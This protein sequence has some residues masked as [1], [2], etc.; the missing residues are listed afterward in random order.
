VSKGRN[1]SKAEGESHKPRREAS[2]WSRSKS[3]KEEEVPPSLPTKITIYG[4]FD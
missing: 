1:I 2:L 3:A 4:R